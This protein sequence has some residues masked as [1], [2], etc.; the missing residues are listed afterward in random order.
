MSTGPTGIGITKNYTCIVLI[1]HLPKT[2]ILSRPYTT[3]AFDLVKTYI[4]ESVG[5]TLVAHESKLIS[6]GLA[7]LE[8]APT[9]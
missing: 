9:I 7:F 6:K 5:N 8:S 4:V 3:T 1:I 2:L